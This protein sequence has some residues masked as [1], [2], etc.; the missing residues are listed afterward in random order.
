V[1]GIE[2]RREGEIRGKWAGGMSGSKGGEVSQTI[3]KACGLNT[4]LARV[5]S[6]LL[7]EAGGKECC[8]RGGETFGDNVLYCPSLEAGTTG[9]GGAK[10]ARRD[11][12]WRGRGQ[13]DAGRWGGIRKKLST[14]HITWGNGRTASREG[15]KRCSD[16]FVER[17]QNLRQKL[18]GPRKRCKDPC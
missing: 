2:R 9:K 13:L 4:L 18:L 14:R 1:G 17:S 15:K 6:V 5:R 11:I 3:R 12:C 10:G 7:Q 16:L 8:A